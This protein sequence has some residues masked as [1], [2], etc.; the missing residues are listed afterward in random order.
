YASYVV[1]TLH[2]QPAYWEIGNDPSGWTHFGVAWSNW[3]TAGGGNT[4]PAPFAALVHAYITAVQAVD[5]SAKFLALGAGLGGK[6]YAKGWV[7]ELASVDG[8]ALSGISVH[9]Y[10]EGGPS[11]P[12]DAELFANLGGFY[13][14]PAQVTADRQYIADACST[15]S[16][17]QVFVTEINAAEV[18]PYNALLPS[19]AG[20]LY[21]AAETVQGLN[22]QVASLDWFAY[23][24][25]FSGSWSTGPEKWQMQYYLFSDIMT[26]LKSDKL[27]TTVTGPSTLYGMATYGHTGLS[28]LLVNVNTT[29][30]VQVNLSAAGFSPSDALTQY[31]WVNGTP[32]PVKS[33]LAAGDAFV[34][35]PMS[36]AVLEGPS[37]SAPTNFP[38]VLSETGLPSGSN[39]SATLNGT[40]HSS[41][42]STIDFS[43]PN[44]TYSFAV[45]APSGYLAA[46]DNGS[47]A[48]SGAGASVPIAFTSKLIPAFAATFVEA[49]LPVGAM[50]NVTLNGTTSQTTSNSLAFWQSNGSYEYTV[51]EVPGFAPNPGSGVVV[52]DGRGVNV[53]VTFDT[54]SVTYAATFSETGLASG[55]IWSIT[56]G[57]GTVAASAPSPVV[58]GLSNGTFAFTV[59]TVTGYAASP[60]MGWV[61]L[62]GAGTTVPVAYG[63]PPAPSNASDGRIYVVEGGVTVSNGSAVPGLGLTLIF[64]GGAP[65][66][67]WLNLTTDSGGRFTASG[68]NLSGNLSVVEVDSPGYQV[69]LTSVT[70]RG[71]DAVNVTVVLRTSPNGPSPGM[72]WPALPFALSTMNVF[73]LAL[74]GIAA[75]LGGAAARAAR[76]DRRMARYR[77]YFANPPR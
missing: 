55:L 71:A 27:P 22:L 50:W 48:V 38:V 8:H 37:Y 9:S 33:Q 2:Y 1:D 20:T 35:P 72:P 58:V 62:E 29:N 61:T 39:W 30:P 63:P 26:H 43:E 10:I 32:L 24:S 60:S 77:K 69:T 28:L 6:N 45:E 68:L 11:N 42:S 3:G 17:L 54:T 53:N 25:H 75:V 12:T 64:R 19:F 18:S 44:G 36:L 34:L 59:G 14:L 74:T 52:V 15:C 76:R 47:V 23:D 70:W 67:E 21:L 56:V 41:S 57:G 51:E 5:P 73:I 49:G 4:T 13:S 16:Q 66:V 65:P 7:E 40:R 31:L 46:P